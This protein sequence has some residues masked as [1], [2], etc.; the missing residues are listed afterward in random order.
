M[1]IVLG[2]WSDGNGSILNQILNLMSKGPIVVSVVPREVHMIGVS[3][4]SIIVFSM[5][6]LFVWVKPE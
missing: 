4:V 6:L 3:S 2:N 5:G 1:P